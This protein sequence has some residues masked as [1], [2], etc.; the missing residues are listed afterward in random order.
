MPG[1]EFGAR[2][3]GGDAETGF[4]ADIG[5]SLAWADIESGLAIE[6]RGRGLLAH[7]ADGFRERGFSA[8]ASWEPG[9]D[10]R[11]PLLSLAQ[12]LGGASAGGAEALLG[13]ATLEG[14]A[15]DGDGDELKRRRLEARLGY[16]FAAFG[17]RFTLTPEAGLGLYN[18]GRDYSLG[19]HLA[20]RP[21]AGPGAAELSFEA[22]RRESAAATPPVHEGHVRLTARF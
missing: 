12:S 15:R 13:R 9:A 16:G 3:D 5:A 17:D 2:H 10:G 20:R 4:G 22:R 18:A 21:G 8:A 19:W 6:L 14:L 1:F 7:K 11:G